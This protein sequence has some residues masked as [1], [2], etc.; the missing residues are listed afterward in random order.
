MK[1]VTITITAIFIYYFIMK[2][3]T[4]YTQ[5]THNTEK[6]PHQSK[7][8]CLQSRLNQLTAKKLITSHI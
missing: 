8:T 6:N 1:H 4:E 3:Y 5:K 7:Q 2:S